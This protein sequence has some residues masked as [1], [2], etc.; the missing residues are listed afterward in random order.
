L[1]IDKLTTAVRDG[2]SSG[3]EPRVADLFPLDAERALHDGRFREAVLF[4]W[5]TIDAVFN[6]KYDSL[7]SVALK[8]EWGAAR[9]FFTGVDFGLRNKMSAVMHLVAHRSLFREPDEL[10]DLLSTSYGK[11]NAIIHRGENATEDEARAALGI[12]RR[13]IG[14]MDSL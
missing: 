1:S 3:G 6:Q 7:V 2:L 13:I 14:V 12:A 11:R 8:G 4:C 5:S 9:D 10:W